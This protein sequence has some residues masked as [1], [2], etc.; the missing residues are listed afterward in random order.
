[1]RLLI[2]ALLLLVLPYAWA[3]T[4]DEGLEVQCDQW[5]MRVRDFDF[6][7]NV[8][9]RQQNAATTIYRESK[10][11]KVSSVVNKHKVEVDFRVLGGDKCGVESLVTLRIDGRLIIKDA[12]IHGCPVG[13]TEIGVMPG[14]DQHGGY[15]FEICGYT[16]S[17]ELPVFNGCV[18]ISAKQLESIKKPLDPSFPVGELIK[19]VK[20]PS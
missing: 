12:Q 19:L 16:R 17:D 6:A 7:N 8:P 9:V 2:G 11:Q 5:Q 18:R 10:P 1:L 15:E 3:D 14:L 13:M 20:F 4:F